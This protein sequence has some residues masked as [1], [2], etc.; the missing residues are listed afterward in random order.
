MLRPPKRLR[1]IEPVLRRALAGPCAIGSGDR[2]LVAVSGGADSTALLRG[3]HRLAHEFGYQLAAAHLHHGLRG[4]DADDDRDFVSRLCDELGV[5][6]MAARWNVRARLRSRGL[7]GQDGMRRLRREF[8]VAAAARTQARWIATAHHADDQ[9]ETLLLRLARGTGLTGLGGIAPRRGR[10]IR[11]LL[12]APRAWIEADLRAAGRAWREDASNADLGYARNRAR[13][14]VIPALAGLLQGA[15]RASLALKAVSVAS[16]ARAAA[17]LLER[18]ARASGVLNVDGG[19]VLDCTR[20]ASLSP[21]G[22]RWL[23]RRAWAMAGSRNGL[24]DRHLKALVR[25]ASPG[26][27]GQ[28]DL[29][30]GMAATRHGDRLSIRRPGSGIESNN[31]TKSRRRTL[32]VPGQ[33]RL[34]GIALRASWLAGERARRRVGESGDRDLLFASDGLEG[35]LELRS[36]RT[37]EWFVPYGRVR[38]RRLGDF[39]KREGLPEV[40]RRRPLVLADQQGILWVVGVRRSARA[41]V[42]PET[43]KALWIHTDRS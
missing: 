31:P 17:R 25:L 34:N 23:A 26:R 35:K 5:P 14:Q 28:L 39:L 3:L 9:L 4:R 43:R 1:R 42:T 6:L 38:P 37:D 20:L 16:E 29:P 2:I 24:T 27:T 12:E 22:V 33:N 40:Q 10:W 15:S 18:R 32:R 30:E 21:L 41:L 13:H 8:L 7:S 19:V 11:P 36:A